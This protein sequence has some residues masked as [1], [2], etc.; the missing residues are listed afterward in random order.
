MI[1]VV[2]ENQ[3]ETPFRRTFAVGDVND[4]KVGV[5]QFHLAVLQAT[6]EQTITLRGFFQS[7]FTRLLLE[8]FSNNPWKW[9]LPSK[10]NITANDAYPLFKIT[11]L[12]SWQNP[13]GH[14]EKI[15]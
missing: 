10:Q 13:V 14:Y 8:D 15:G 5:K 1:L 2:D 12:F 3:G 11:L 7:C 4:K 6:P 9:N